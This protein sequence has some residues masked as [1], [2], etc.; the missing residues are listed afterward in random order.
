[1]SPQ[2]EQIAATGAAFQPVDGSDQEIR[3]PRLQ[4]PIANFA[5]VHHRD[6]D[7]R[8]VLIAEYAAQPPDRLDAVH[9]GHLVVRQHHVYG[10]LAGIFDGFHRVGK[11]CDLQ[12]GIE[13]PHDLAQDDS[14]GGLIVDYDDLK[15]CKLGFAGIMNQRKRSGRIG[16]H[17]SPP[18]WN[19]R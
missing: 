8:H 19:G 12:A 13:T 4:R 18:A 3:R 10:V 2:A 16:F 5:I 17:G 1:M 11:G 6:A 9:V 7:D 14:P 15:G